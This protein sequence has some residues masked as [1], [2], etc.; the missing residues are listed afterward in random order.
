MDD[1][2][3]KRELQ[4][5]EMPEKTLLEYNNNESAHE[6]MKYGYFY[7]AYGYWVDEFEELKDKEMYK[8]QKYEEE[9]M[10]STVVRWDARHGEE[11]DWEHPCD[12]YDFSE[13]D[14][15]TI[16]QVEILPPK[17]V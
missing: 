12:I 2:T 1:K 9:D 10:E 4:L 8:G 17:E 16:D 13:G 14:E 11:L 5:Y 3:K 6:K 7:Q 15:Y